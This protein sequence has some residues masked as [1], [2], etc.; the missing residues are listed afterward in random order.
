MA[1][2]L[3]EKASDSAVTVTGMAEAGLVAIAAE[4]EVMKETGL[5]TANAGLG[6]RPG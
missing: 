1:G 3:E 6:R 2:S 4:K 5:L